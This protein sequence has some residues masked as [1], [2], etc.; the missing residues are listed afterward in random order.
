VGRDKKTDIALLKVEPKKDLPH[1]TLGDSDAMRVGDWVIAIGNPYGL[2]GSVTQGIISARQRSINAGPFDDFLQTDAPINRGN[3]G[4]PLFNLKGELIGINTAIFSP[5]GGSI[6]IGFAIPTALARPVIEQLKQF[7]HTQRGWLG[8]KI[9]QVSEEVADSVGLA[10]PMGALVLEVAKD[11]PADK[12]GLKAGDIITGF[13]GRDISEMRFLP[14]MVAE[15]RINRQVSISYWRNNASKSTQITVGELDERDEEDSAPK[16]GNGKQKD[17]KPDA[18]TVMGMQLS[19]LSPKLREQLNVPEATNGVA[20]VDIAGS[21]EA[22]RRGMRAGDVIVDIN[23]IPVKSAEDVRKAFEAAL[24]SGRKFALVRVA[25]EKEMAFMTLPA[26]DE[27]KEKAKG[28][29]D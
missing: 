21:S 22:A 2:G 10:R 1:V 4:G 12:A 3:S 29:N 24:K 5:S 19:P 25:R 26:A 17:K 9:Q 11:G 8:I 15:T 16:G 20:V 6:G 7:G 18:E 27:K 13:D 23:N 14:R 28:G